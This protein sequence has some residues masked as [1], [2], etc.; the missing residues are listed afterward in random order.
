MLCMFVCCTHVCVCDGT[1]THYS[2]YSMT[3]HLHVLNKMQRPH[4]HSYQGIEVVEYT[5]DPMLVRV[6]HR[7]STGQ[8]ILPSSSSKSTRQTWAQCDL[9][10][11]SSEAL[12]LLMPIARSQLQSL[13]ALMPQLQCMQWPGLLSYVHMLSNCKLK[14]WH[15]SSANSR[16]DGIAGCSIARLAHADQISHT[17]V[18]C[19]CMLNHLNYI[20]T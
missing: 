6:P 7:V 9:R 4:Y 16:D 17:A 11:Q 5:G 13:Q 12:V 20:A 10:L 3:L 1:V 14:V 8:S 18:L 19:G 15:A 2:V